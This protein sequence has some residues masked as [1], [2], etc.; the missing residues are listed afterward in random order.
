M[1]L[2]LGD[3]L[4]HTI[5]SKCIC[6]IKLSSEGGCKIKSD[7][8]YRSQSP[9]GGRICI[10]PL[11]AGLPDIVPVDNKNLTMSN[12]KK[13]ELLVPPSGV[14]L[15]RTVNQLVV[16]DIIKEVLDTL[17]LIVSKSPVLYLSNY[18]RQSKVFHFPAVFEFT[19]GF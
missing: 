15:T 9:L 17:M 5:Y 4:L 1:N 11:Y 6:I 3:S 19:L 12:K 13:H 7:S 2:L 18:V 10:R 8:A 14:T 16:L